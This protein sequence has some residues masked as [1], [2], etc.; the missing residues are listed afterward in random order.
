[1]QPAAVHTA[2]PWLADTLD[3][4][5]LWKHAD[6][7]AGFNPAAESEDTGSNHLFPHL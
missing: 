1:M 3:W 4:F 5:E 6:D 7:I 2:L